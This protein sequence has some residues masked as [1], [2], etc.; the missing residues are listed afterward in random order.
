MAVYPYQSQEVRDL[1]WACFSPALLLS[2]ALQSDIGNAVFTLTAQRRAWLE[3]LDRDAGPLLAHLAGQRNKRLGLYFESLWHFFLSNDPEVE[4]I[5]NN[6][7]VYT[8]DRTLGE[9]DCIY[10]CRRRQQHVHLELAVKFYLGAPAELPGGE[11]SEWRNWLGPNTRDRLDLKLSHL[12]Q[13]QIRLSDLPPASAELRRL[14]IEHPRR[15]IE[16]KGYL[17]QPA[18]AALPPPRGFNPGQKFCDW[19]SIDRLRPSLEQARADGFQVL[20]R[21][22][23]LSP[24]RADDF[25]AISN[26]SRLADALSAHFQQ[27]ERPLLV[28]AF[29]SHGDETTRFFVTGAH[30]PN[31]S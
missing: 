2:D 9:F 1:A 22:H 17:F 14:G 3:R 24:A 27:S 21:S 8:D 12:L 7:P 16:I 13:H 23:W 26:A 6:L 10:Y 19:L 20:P 4:L 28:A 11:I 18:D 25:Q 31:L 30:W 5:A 15:E 29:D